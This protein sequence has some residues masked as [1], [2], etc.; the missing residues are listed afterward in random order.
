MNSLIKTTIKRPVAICVLVVILLAVGVLSTLDMSTNL[1]PNINMPM[2]GITAIYPGAGASSVQADV[3]DKLE[4]VLKTIP[5]V[6]ELDARSYDNVSVCVLTFDYGTDIDKKIDDIED[7]FKTVTLPQGCNEPTFTK[8]DMN[9]TAAATISVYNNEGD[10]ELLAD[11]VDVLATKLRAIEGVGSVKVMGRPTKQIQITSLQG[12]DITALAVVQALSQENLDLPLGTILQ[13]GA[14]VSVRNASD[15]TSMLQIMQLPVTMDLGTGVLGS[16][17]SLKTAVSKYATCTLDEFNDYVNK[18]LDARRVIEEI[19]GKTSAE[20]E[21]QQNNLASIKS[22]MALVRQNG[23]QSLRLMWHTIETNLVHNE[24]FINMSDD[25]L[26]AL[27]DNGNTGLSYDVLKWLQDGAKDGTLKDDW[28]KL[29]TFRE[30]MENAGGENFN[31]DDITYDHFANLFQNGGSV[32]YAVEG[33]P[34]QLQTDVYEGLDLLHSAFDHGQCGADCDRDVFT[35]GEAADVCEFADSVNT[36]AYQQIIDA[37]KEAEENPS[38]AT[39][40]II[41]DELFAALFVNSAQGDEFAALMSPQVIHVIRLDNFNAEADGKESIVAVLTEV[42][43]AHVDSYG[44][45]VYKNGKTVTFDED[46]NSAVIINGK[47]YKINGFGRITDSDGNLADENGNLLTVT[48]GQKES[49]YYTYGNYRVFDDAELLSLYSRLSLD[50]DTFGIALTD[51]VTRFVRITEFEE[52]ASTLIVPVAYVGKVQS[53]TA[54]DAY[55][56]YNG[57]PAVTLEVY[58]VADANTTAVVNAVKAAMGQAELKG[59]MKLLDDKAEFINDSIMNVLTS[60]IIGGVLAILV[61][62]LFVGKIRSSLV[63]SITMPLSVLAALLG[64]WAMDISLNMVSLGGLAVGIGML[65]DNSI[66]VLES[67]TKRRDRGES[68]FDSC[69]N[70]TREV[71]GSLL[72]ST[73]TNICVFFPIL[74]AQ[75]LTREIF[76]DLVWAVLF[77]IVMSLIVAVTVIPSLY[78]LVYAHSPRPRYRKDKNGNKVLTGTFEDGEPRGKTK[79]LYDESAVTADNAKKVL[80]VETEDKTVPAVAADCAPNKEGKQRK[81]NKKVKKPVDRAERKR[82]IL[83]RMENGYGALLTKVLSRRILVCVLALVIFGASVGLVFTTGTDFLPSVDKG[84]IEVNLRFNGAATLEEADRATAAAAA[85]ITEEYTDGE[86]SKLEYVSYTVGKQ[87]MLPL[88]VTGVIRIKTDLSKLDTKK[89]VNDIRQLL[90]T[91]K[92]AATNITVAEIDGVVAELTGEMAGQSVT[93]LADNMESLA[94]AASAI[95]E[96]LQDVD[97][98]ASVTDNTPQENDEISLVFDKDEC[99]RRGVDYQNAV[100]MLRVGMSGYTAATVT[101]DN[102]SR[103]VNVIFDD[104]TKDTIEQLLNVAVGFD[105]DG[106]IKIADVLKRTEDGELYS[107]NKAAANINKLNGKF[108]TTI[109]IESYNVDMGTVSSRTEKVV[110]EVLADYPDVVYQEGGVAHYLSDAMAGLVISLIAAFLLLYGVM[111]CQ[112]ES[113]IKPLIVIASIP[114]SFTGGFL[115]LVITGTTLNVVSFVGIIMLMGVIVNG[116]IVM[117]DKIDQLIKEGKTPMEAVTEGCKSRLRPILMTTLTTILA[118]IPLALGLGRGGELMQ[119]MGIV[120]IGGLLLG[121]LVTLA[122]I[123]CFYCIVKRVKFAPVEKNGPNG[124]S[125]TAELHD[126]NG[127]DSASDISVSADGSTVTTADVSAAETVQNGLHS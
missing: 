115:A 80:S 11:D 112:F 30:C 84:V 126:N 57:K 67:I 68:V 48:D 51:D 60:I 44:N 27:A 13:N 31:G 10:V 77:S 127:T 54:Y 109:D 71:A 14:V 73:L 56:L 55:S 116:A 106:A 2:V 124:G 40:P 99:A 74:F 95:A 89:T 53:I 70:G 50:E 49:N 62:Y 121:T 78:H 19:E 39:D 93:L 90:K 17:Y 107:V 9:G 43:K 118:L 72:A 110:N 26:R 119:P 20:L 35:H 58:A 113:L 63:V 47:N 41:T 98:I 7:V 15:A 36:V 86:D 125:G 117:I 114:F 94:A 108:V 52:N 23:S 8:I 81:N 87:G 33:N 18:A 103:A 5:G 105:D 32:E 3:T 111:A 102:E 28:F 29:V 101:V 82:S 37:V 96:R 79:P 122:L 6:T 104:I 38:E 59:E 88:N 66:V 69:L 45:A 4:N 42:K 92:I 24:E 22:L 16:L 1:L 46:N 123:P 75:G 61:I 34:A 83:Y 64:L 25:D 91:K 65:V 97:G 76:Y 21:E 120:V 85:A 12:L 100:L